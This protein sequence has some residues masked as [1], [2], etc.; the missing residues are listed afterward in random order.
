[1]RKNRMA[2][3]GVAAVL[4]L[5]GCAGSGGSSGSTNPV[6]IGTSLSLTGSLG[7]LGT[8]EQHG[9]RS[10]VDEVNASGGLLVGHA[11]RPVKLVVLDNR[12]DPNM[13]G[14]QA[15]ELTLRD[16][17]AALL[18]PCTPPIA[19]PVALVAEAQRVPMV[20]SCVPTGAFA[21]G[22]KAGWH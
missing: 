9:Y 5:S 20:S 7:P 11:R 14:E 4:A 12:S 10:A 21:E 8:L 18:G 22:N 6:I 17:V 16:N 13:A 3:I 19:I 15:R 2:F 1:M